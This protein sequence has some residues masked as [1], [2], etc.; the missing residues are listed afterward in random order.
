MTRTRAAL[1]HLA[2]SALIVG[3]VLTV[4]FL[5][6]YPDYLFE[7]SGAIDPVLVM[8]GVDVT[9]GPILTFIV[10]K[11][12]KPG[13]KFD[14]AVIFTVQI[15]A[16]LYGSITLY[17]ERPHFLVFAID[18]F[19]AIPARAVDMDALRYDELRS[20]TSISPV[21]VY[22]RMPED[23]EVRRKF[24]EGVLFDGEPDL[25]RRA[26]F[27]EPYEN[28]AA[29]VRASAVDIHR[30]DPANDREAAEIAAARRRFEPGHPAL[31]IV[32]T[33]SFADDYALVIDLASLEPLTAIR[34]DAWQADEPGPAR[35][36]APAATR[37]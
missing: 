7:L 21:L 25:E 35:T 32:P 1:I 12:G 2:V 31:G 10:F 15:A 18:N 36:G 20:K 6:W 11:A 13:L 9:L 29:Q 24:T 26:E 5:A 30:F 34:V 19:V 16:L 23:P 37:E 28:G 14:L 17:R 22:A 3:S 4:V 27:F 33:R 8:L